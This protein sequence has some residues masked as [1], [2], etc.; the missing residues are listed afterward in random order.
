MSRY[1]GGVSFAKLTAASVESGSKPV[2]L[3]T[4]S[5]VLA[6]SDMDLDLED[7]ERPSF[8]GFAQHPWT[9]NVKKETDQKGNTM[10]SQYGI[11]AKL[12]M[13][14]GYQKGMGLGSKQDGIAAPIE[15]KLRPQGLGVG[16]VQERVKKSEQSELSHEEKVITF[17]KPTYDLFPLIESIENHDLQVPQVYKELADSDDADP[18]QLERSY[19]KLLN[20]HTEIVR[21]DQQLRTLKMEITRT[22]EFLHSDEQEHAKCQ[23]LQGILLSQ[24]TSLDEIT[25]CLER[26]ANFGASNSEEVSSAFVALA[27]TRSKELFNSSDEDSVQLL[28]KWA[29]LYRELHNG[30]SAGDLN[31]WDSMIYTLMEDNFLTSASE[32][33]RQSLSVWLASPVIIDTPLVEELCLRKIVLPKLTR[34]IDDWTMMSAFDNEILECILGFNWSS[35]LYDAIMEALV[36]KY[37]QQFGESGIWHSLLRS[38]DPQ[39]LYFEQIKRGLDDYETI[40]LELINQH[41]GKETKRLRDILV[42][43][44]LSYAQSEADWEDQRDQ[45]ALMVLCDVATEYHFLSL[46]QLEM[47]LQFRV[48]NPILFRLRS[49]LVQE[50]DTRHWFQKCKDRFHALAKQ[51]PD[52][53]SIFLWYTNRFLKEIENPSAASCP[54][55]T[56]DNDVLP[57]DL[58]SVVDSV[59]ENDDD[60]FGL[61]ELELTA[62]FKDVVLHLCDKLKVTFTYSGTTDI[63]MN[64]IYNLEFMSGK[65]LRCYI[66]DD[67]LWVQNGEHFAPVD[68]EDFLIETS[69]DS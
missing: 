63:N 41:W 67:V 69:N 65:K 11:G 27:S 36:K 7:D 24:L 32:D 3:D 25:A 61:A 13:Q 9:N 14:M 62:T 10:I 18:I 38:S 64:K 68:A 33:M 23:Q 56:F 16:G 66:S 1:T 22:E 30:A 15:V 26:L 20:L 43:G 47:I 50:G 44:L 40:V 58:M 17:S 45:R 8:S 6:E 57:S 39:A 54:I 46:T 35:E 60:V 48:L 28:A 42:R 49:L 37:E 51:Y 29:V 31:M 5:A 12:L 59:H 34:N 52:V 21:L 55:P 19:T 53:K 4:E 2:I